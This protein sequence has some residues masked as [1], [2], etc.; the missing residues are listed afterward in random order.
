VTVSPATWMNASVSA[1]SNWAS[2]PLHQ[3]FA[4]IDDD[5]GEIPSKPEA[6]ANLP[7]VRNVAAFMMRANSRSGALCVKSPLG[8]RSTLHRRSWK[9]AFFAKGKV[10]GFV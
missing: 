5:T 6:D 9:V 8:T 7:H 2:L 10:I 1:S 3:L 4:I